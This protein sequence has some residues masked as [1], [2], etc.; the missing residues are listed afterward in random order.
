MGPPFARTGPVHECAILNGLVPSKLVRPLPS[1]LQRPVSSRGLSTYS[2]VEIAHMRQSVGHRVL[3]KTAMLVA[4]VGF[5]ALADA[6]FRPPSSPA[7]GEDYHVEAGIIWWNPEPT[8]IVSSESLGILGTD[9]DLVDDLGIEQKRIPELRFVLRPAKKHK[10]R[11]DYLPMKYE[12]ESTVKREFVFNGQRYRVGL[13]V[14][15]TA[16]LTTWRLGYE[17]DFVS[18]PRGFVGVLLDLKY[19][20]VRVDLLSPIGVEFTDQVAP[21]PTLGLIGR[22]YVSPNVS[23]TGEFGYLKVPDRLSDEFDGRYIDFDFYGTVNF[24]NNVGAQFGYKSIDVMYS[25]SDDAGRLKF[26][27][28]YFA[29]VARF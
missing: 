11:I 7:V 10:F 13:P 27:G 16:E 8:L 9:V 15:T 3:V 6:Q 14:Q 18:L 4:L 22:G 12:A 2:G 26:K 20:D 28:W 21:I 19:T 1:G 25:E 17:Y 29:G 24:T 23:I 5:P